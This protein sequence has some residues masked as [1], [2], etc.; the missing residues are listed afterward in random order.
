LS[1]SLILAA[2]SLAAAADAPDPLRVEAVVSLGA[3]KGRIDHLAADI[4]RHWLFVAERNNDTVAIVDVRARTLHRV[5]A[6]FDEPQGVGYEP[7]TDTLYVT[8][9]GDGS[10]RMFSA[11][12]L[13]P[14]GQIDLGADADNVRIDASSNQVLVGFGQGLAVID[15][16][17]HTTRTIALRGHPEAFQLVRGTSRVFVN[18]PDA[19][20]VTVVDLQSGEQTHMPIPS[21]GANF[22]MALDDA[23]LLLLP[24]RH[25]AELLVIRP[26]DAATEAASL[27]E[28]ADDTFFDSARRRLYVSCG[29]GYLDVF[30]R[31]D[32]EYSRRAHIRTAVGARTSLLVPEWDRLFLAV[33][34]SSSSKAAIWIMKPS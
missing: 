28:D 34:E 14:A 3:V 20:E 25:P 1:A 12:S 8:N 18:V 26:D 10:V 2:A 5:I 27:C 15:A 6:G 9:G 16:K 4:D 32:S 13:E 33:P 29:D 21:R 30:Q 19:R 17:N 23:R 31:L 22:P 7:S 24:L 11:A